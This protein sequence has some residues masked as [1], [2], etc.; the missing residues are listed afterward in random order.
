MLG[1]HVISSEHGLRRKLENGGPRE[2][3]TVKT[4]EFLESSIV[5]KNWRGQVP[6]S[7]EALQNRLPGQSALFEKSELT[8]KHPSKEN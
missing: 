4:K 3:I 1:H 8:V 2:I 6:L 7:S 5:C